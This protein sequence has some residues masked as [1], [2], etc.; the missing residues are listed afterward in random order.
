MTRELYVG[1]LNTP[2]LDAVIEAFNGI[3]DRQFY[4]NHGP[5]VA[6]FEDSLAQ[7]LGVR[8][9][10][11]TTNATVALMIGAKSIG[12]TGEV[13]VPAYTFPATIEALTFA[14]LTPVFCDVDPNTHNITP[15][16]VKAALTSDATAICGVHL[17]GRSC[18]IEGLQAV[19]DDNGLKLCFDAAHAFGCTHQG[20]LIGGF[21]EFEVFSFHATKVLNC[22]EGGCVTTNDDAI[23]AAIRTARN[24]HEQQTFVDVPLRINAKMSEAQA[25]MGIISLRDFGK[26][27]AANRERYIRYQKRLDGIPG[28]DF[29]EHA[30]SEASN[31]QY[32]VVTVDKPHYGMSQSELMGVLHEHGI[33]A[34]RYFHPGM[35]KAYPYATRDWQLPVTDR[36]CE[37][38]LQLPSGDMV[39]DTDIDRVSALI[40]ELSSLN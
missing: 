2:D 33:K 27:I 39:T 26:V 36:L 31:Y 18:D 23:A 24:F 3:F 28:I 30:Q 29:V 37:T 40:A 19:A 12:L 10:I 13:V 15:E 17:W 4:T 1:Q 16:S 25:A 21:G 9:A 6:E 34:R 7:Y 32:V 11:C 8:H 35:H 5:L 38:V 22:T 20:R 14:G